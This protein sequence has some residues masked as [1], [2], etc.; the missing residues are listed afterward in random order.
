MIRDKYCTHT[1]NRLYYEMN[2]NSGH[3]LKCTFG[4]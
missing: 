1:V 3:Q 2:Q 4:I